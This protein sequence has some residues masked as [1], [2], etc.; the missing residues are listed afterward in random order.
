MASIAEQSK[1]A[2][3]MYPCFHL[4]TSVQVPL[5]GFSRNVKQHAEPWIP[6]LEELVHV[7]DP[8]QL[9]AADEDEVVKTCLFK[10][11]AYNMRVWSKPCVDDWDCQELGEPMVFSHIVRFD[12]DTVG[13]IVSD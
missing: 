5:S 1:G 8:I 12:G 6:S 7:A 10:S 4:I 13:Y 2:L 9:D 11:V 3:G